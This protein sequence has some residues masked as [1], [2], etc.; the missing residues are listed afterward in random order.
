MIRELR[1]ISREVPYRTI[2]AFSEPSLAGMLHW[3]SQPVG[4]N[5]IFDIER[6]LGWL[7]VGDFIFNYQHLR[8]KSLLEASHTRST[9]THLANVC[10]LEHLAI[11]HGLLRLDNTWQIN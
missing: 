5:V 7:I 11:I 4:P 9:E 1:N 3:W 10:D 8:D 2:D 6:A